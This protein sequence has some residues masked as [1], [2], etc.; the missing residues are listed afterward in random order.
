MVNALPIVSMKLS[1]P[2]QRP[3][4]HDVLGRLDVVR[5]ELGF[6]SLVALLFGL[7]LFLPLILQESAWSDM[8]EQRSNEGIYIVVLLVVVLCGDE[9]EQAFESAAV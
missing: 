9:R 7:L 3:L 2:F 5:V 1:L 6:A 8:L 4:V